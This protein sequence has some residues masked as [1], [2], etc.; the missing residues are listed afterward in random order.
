MSKEYRQKWL[1][2]KL[3]ANK[4]R[5]TRL[6]NYQSSKYKS[7]VLT[8]EG[9][10]VELDREEYDEYVR[11]IKE[12]KRE[13]RESISTDAESDATVTAEPITASGRIEKIRREMEELSQKLDAEIASSNNAG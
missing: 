11:K 10:K 12:A 3:R 9:N 13:F 4:G 8:I 2:S 1:A 5:L 7:V 6:G